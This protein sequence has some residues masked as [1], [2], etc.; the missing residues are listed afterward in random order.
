MS[1]SFLQSDRPV[2]LV[3][4]GPVGAG[5]LDW[6]LGIAPVLAAADGGAAVALAAGKTPRAVIGDLDSLSPSTRAALPA[7]ALDHVA[8]QES[9]DFEKC[10]SRIDAPGFVGLGF[11][12]GWIDHTLAVLACLA[13]RRP[14]CVL[15][16]E[17][18]VA[19]AAP[20]GLVLDLAPGTRVSLFPFH[21][22][23]GRS[24]GLRWPIDGLTLSPSGRIGT[25]NE[26]LGPV[27]LDA[28]GLVVLLPR[29]LRDEAAR[30]LLSSSG[31]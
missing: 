24:S 17:A 4:G 23:R 7:E 8:E 5:D 19:F 10:L 9:T 30:A 14:R 2:T 6:A 20:P 12:G 1:E 25:S 28:P 21:E 15:L 16:G 18:E 26:A 11:L 22:V 13:R 27:T 31:R 29:A 3:G